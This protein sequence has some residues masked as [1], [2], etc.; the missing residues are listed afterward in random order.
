MPPQ[1]DDLDAYRLYLEGRHHWNQ[2]TE[3][4]LARSVQLFQQAVTADPEFAKAYAAMAAAYV[5]LGT[6]GALAPGAAMSQTRAAAGRALDIAPDLADAY[7]AR[8]AV[9]A[10]HDWVWQDAEEDFTHAISLAPQEPSIHQSYAVNCLVPRR[11][12]DEARRQ[13]DHAV[14]LD[15][16]SL[17]VRTSQGLTFYYAGDY[18]R[19]ITELRRTLELEQ[20]FGLARYFLGLAYAAAEQLDHACDEADRAVALLGNSSEVV[21][22][23]GYARALAGDRERALEVVGE[24]TRRT[25]ERYVSPLLIGQIQAALGDGPAA[26]DCV[27]RAHV[28]RAPDVAWAGLRPAFASLRAEPRFVAILDSVGVS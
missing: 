13:L 8:G 7:A 5:T 20:N 28:E 23:Q 18:A 9:R 19:A 6:Y 10:M 25:Q 26:L 22:A 15:P 16:L 3:D 4:G 14:A 12:F 1:T 24:L 17:V 27:E 2:R 11:R 21:A